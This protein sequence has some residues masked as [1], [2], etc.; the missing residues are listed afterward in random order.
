MFLLAKNC[1]M[2]CLP[3]PITFQTDFPHAKIF[4]DNLPNT[5]LFHVQLTCD[6]SYSQLTIATQLLPY[7]LD[8]D[9]CLACWRPPASGVIFHLLALLFELLL[10]SC[11]TQKHVCNMVLFPHTCWSISSVCDGIFPNWTKNFRFIH[12]SVSIAH[13]WMTWESVNKIMWKKYNGC[14]KLSLQVYTPKMLC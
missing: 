9:L 5:V 14:R 1:Q 13:S 12:C 6:H 4:S 3:S 8:I 11:A 2:L 7:L 10:T